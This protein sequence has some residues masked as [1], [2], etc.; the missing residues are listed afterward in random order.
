MKAPILTLSLLSLLALAGC[1]HLDPAYA[2][3][4][5]QAAPT[6]PSSLDLAGTWESTRPYMAGGWG[7]ADITQTGTRFHGTLGPFTLEG[8]VAGSKAYTLI[9]SGGRVYYTAI[10]EV[11][12]KGD[13]V[14]QAVSNALPD[15]PEAARA[16][17]APVHLVRTKR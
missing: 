2:R 13:L 3:D 11:D 9:L 12:A 5:V 17:H 14:G 8:K 1:Q 10:L 16:E 6:A 4:W 15:S 7:S